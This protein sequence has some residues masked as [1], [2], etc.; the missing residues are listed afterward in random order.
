MNYEFPVIRRIDDVLPHIEGREEFIVAKRDF[1]TV[2]NYNVTMPDTFPPIKVAGGTAKMREQRSLTNRMRRECRGLIF[3][4]D[5][6]IMSRPF[7]KFFNVG[8]REETQIKNIDITAPHVIMEKMDG[9]MIRPLMDRGKMRLGTKMGITDISEDA[10]R[11]LSRSDDY[12]EKTDWLIHHFKYL[13]VTPLFE[14]ISPKNQIVVNYDESDLVLLAVRDNVTGKY[15]SL[16][17]DIPFTTVPTYGSVDGSFKE[18]IERQK[19]AQGREGDIIRFDNGHMLKIKNDWYVRI[20][21]AL[22]LV[23]FDRN[24]VD[25]ILN[26]E[27]DDVVPMMPQEEIDRIREYEKRFWDAFQ[28]KEVHLRNQY[29]HAMKAYK[30]DR[31]QIALNIV[32][33]LEH[34][35]DASFIFRMID[36]HDLRDLLLEH[37]KKNISTNVKWEACEKW[38]VISGT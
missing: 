32:P 38:M 33:K 17:G 14:W 26:E 23:R 28:R 29:H 19:E 5:G 20:H 13:E 18:Y 36:G 22:D 24:I 11:W 8:E 12:E 6:R 1:G 7:H 2:I 25:L 10:E 9:S 37:V 21:K 31:K 15:L 3:Y 30:G 34:K 35:A 16:K 27:L 4:P